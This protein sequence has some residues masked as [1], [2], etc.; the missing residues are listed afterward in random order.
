MKSDIK[1]AVVLGGGT[2]GAQVAAHLVAQGVEVTLLDVV[3]KEGDRSAV[4][5]KAVE[6]LK[7]LKPSPLHLPEHATLIRPGN[8]EDDWPALKEA[9]WVFEAV[10]EDLEIKRQLFARVA[11]AVKP[12]AL[13]ATN[14]SGLGIDAMSAHLPDA[15]RQRFLGTHFFNP[16]RYLKL[17]ETIPGSRTSPAALAATEA[18]ADRVLGKAVVRCKDTPNFIGNRI[19]S[20]GMG[21][22]LQAMVDLDLTVEDADTLTG[23]A[24]GRR[25]QRHLPHRGHRGRRRVRQG[26][27]RT[28]TT[29]C[30]DDPFR[31]VFKVPDFMKAMVERGL[32]GQKAGAGFYKKE[33][34]EI[35][36]LDW[37]TLEYRERRKPRFPSLDAAQNV[38]DLGARLNQI[39]AG[40]DQGAAFLWRVLSGT[41]L[42]AAG[43]VPEIS[44]DVV[45]IDRAMEWGY[46]WGHGT[47]PAARHAGRGLGRRPRA[48]RGPHDPAAGR[49]SAGV[50]AQAVLRHG[51]RGHHHVRTH[52]NRAGGGP[53]GRH[54][55]R[56]AEG[57]RGADQEEPR[58]QPGRPGRRSGPRRVPL[59]D[60]HAR[61]RHLL[62]ALV[63]GQGGPGSLRRAGDR[64]P[65]RAVHASAPTSCWPCWPSQEEEWD[66][67]DLSIRQFQNANMA[68][69]YSD[70]PGGGGAVRHG[71]GRRLRDQPARH[72]HP[73][74][75]RDLHGPGRGRRGPRCLAAA[76]PRRWRCA[77]TTAAR[78]CPR[79]TR[80]RS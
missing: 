72:P 17:L 53:S 36:T 54:R 4:A 47:V 16:P 42:Y 64:E 7:K 37:K 20:F 22:V 23:P 73:L 79:R 41:S 74:L 35:R 56:R 46:G 48:D 39:F 55:R 57:T 25:A 33:G 34:D 70:L 29:R 63:R 75:R 6:Y 32:L 67:I 60:E 2:M 11:S 43:L 59:E 15:F 44:D 40:Q 3:A 80:S 19:G 9:D 30:P 27:L 5:K 8:F 71:A 58:R 28:S 38:A 10:V 61:H 26:R 77:R 21:A 24:I 69:K 68:L 13:V 62:H 51:G 76:A 14:T 18:F 52:R 45:S 1:K 49:A 65:G 12:T 31:E 50:G 66:E 78:A